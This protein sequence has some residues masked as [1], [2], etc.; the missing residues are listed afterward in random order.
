MSVSVGGGGTV[1][2]GTSTQE[3]IKWVDTTASSRPG[4]FIVTT[5]KPRLYLRDFWVGRDIGEITSQFTA[6]DSGTHARVNVTV[7]DGAGPV[8][9]HTRR[10]AVL[11]GVFIGACVG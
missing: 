1:V 11:R 2:G 6:A 8:S 3:M 4:S 7:M 5:A 10:P 9:A